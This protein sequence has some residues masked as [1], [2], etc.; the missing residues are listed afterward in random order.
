MDGDTD[1][2][3]RYRQRAEEERIIAEGMRDQTAKG[4]LLMVAEDYERMADQWDTAGEK[5]RKLAACEN[6]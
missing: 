6:L 2:A 3:A 5:D 4:T 1:T